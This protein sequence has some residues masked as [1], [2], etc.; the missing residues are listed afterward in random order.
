[1]TG[2]GAAPADPA[3]TA[4]L[5]ATTLTGWF[6]ATTFVAAAGI[7]DHPVL[8]EERA[9][10]ARA[11]PGRQRE[12]ATG[13]WLARQGLRRFGHPDRP[14]GI[15]RLRGPVWP[16]GILG[17]LSHDGGLCAAVLLQ[18]GGGIRGIGIDLAWLPRQA[19]RL[20]GMAPIFVAE[21]SELAAVRQLGLIAEPELVLFSLKEAI[22]KALAWRLTDFVDLR[23]IVVT[24]GPRLGCRV[25]GAPIGVSLFAAIAGDCLVTGA[26]MAG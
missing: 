4:A 12:F 25:F 23:D 14:I 19:G 21:A 20:P 9:L 26:V 15:G 16:A 24:G 18:D 6:P 11:V 10:M 2:S 17:T 8:P 3:A 13:R 22:V 5:V 1:M 7:D